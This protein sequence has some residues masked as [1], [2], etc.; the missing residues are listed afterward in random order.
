MGKDSVEISASATVLVEAHKHVHD[1]LTASTAED[2]GEPDRIA[3]H[4]AQHVINCSNMELEATQAAGIV[5]GIASSGGSDSIEYIGA[6]DLNKVA[7]AAANMELDVDLSH[8]PEEEEEGADGDG[9]EDDVASCISADNSDT[10]EDDSDAE[11]VIGHHAGCQTGC[12]ADGH[13]TSCSANCHAGCSANCHVGCC[14]DAEHP[15]SAL[16]GQRAR[17]CGPCNASPSDDEKQEDAD[18]EG[19]G[20]LEREPEI[21]LLQHFHMD[22]GNC[23]GS[24]KTYHDAEGNPVVVAAAHHYAYRDSRLACFN[25]HEFHRIFQLRKMDST[26]YPRDRIWHRVQTQYLPRLLGAAHL[27]SLIRRSLAA[28]LIQ[29]IFRDRYKQW[30][31]GE[32]DAYTFATRI[33]LRM[34]LLH[35]RNLLRARIGGGPINERPAALPLTPQNAKGRHVLVARER[36]PDYDCTEHDGTGWEAKVIKATPRWAFVDFVH[37]RD[38]HG[39]RYKREWIKLNELQP[40]VVEHTPS[41]VGRPCER[42]L[43]HAPHPLHDSHII[44]RRAKW[45]VTAPAGKPPPSEPDPDK[46]DTRARRRAAGEFARYYSALFIPWTAWSPPGRTYEHWIMHVNQLEKDACLYDPREQ[47]GDELARR[48][49]LIAAARLFDIESLKE[50][51]NA[52]KKSSVLNMKLRSMYRTFWNDSNRPPL[53]ESDVNGEQRSAAKEIQKLR[54]KAERMRGKKDIATRLNEANTAK[55]AADLLRAQLP[56]QREG[57]ASVPGSKLCEL[58]RSAA[59]PARRTTRGVSRDVRDVSKANAQPIPARNVTSLRE[60]PNQLPSGIPPPWLVTNPTVL[61]TDSPFAEITSNDYDRAVADWKAS[62]DAGLPVDKPPLNPEQRDGGRDFLRVARLRAGA[63]QRGEPIE[64]IAQAVA[65]EELSLVTLAMGAG[66]TGK[67]EMVHELDAQMQ[68]MGC[69]HLLVTAYTGVAAA[70][71]KGPTL[72]S[73][74]NLGVESKNAKRVEQMSHGRRETARKKFFN[75]CGV[76]IENIGGIVI[77]EVSFNELE[78]FG[79]L[80]GRLRQLTGNMDVLCGG[81]P[82]LLCG[83]NFQKPPTTGNPWYKDMAK[84]AEEQGAL[85]AGGPTTSKARG[86]ELLQA[87]RRVQLWRNMR[88]RFDQPFVEVQEQMRNTD[89][90][91]PVPAAFVR[92]LRKV[93]NRDLE[94]DEEWRFAPVGVLQREERDV[95]NVAQAEAF[96]RTFGVPLIRWRLE[97]VDEIDDACLRIDVY[98]DED[99]LWGYF[100]EGAPI[101]LTENISSTR[102]LVNGS[103]GILDSLSFA[104]RVIPPELQAAYANA[105]SLRGVDVVRV[106][107]A[108]APFSVNVRVGGVKSPPGQEPGSAPGSV[109]W[110]GVELDDLSSVIESVTPEA[111]VVS[112]LMSTNV[113]K[114]AVVLRGLVAAQNSLAEKVM[115]AKQHAY[116]LAFALTD[117]K[118][119]GR[120]LPKLI[121]NIFKRSTPPWMNLASFYVLISRCRTSDSLRLLQY[122]R[123][124]LEA[125]CA[126]KHDDYLVAWE[127]AYDNGRWSDALAVAA[128]ER[129]RR[130]RQQAKAARAAEKK[131]KDAQRT[132]A[133]RKEAAER[134]RAEKKAKAAA[135]AASP[136]PQTPPPILRTRSAS[137]CAPATLSRGQPAHGV[138]VEHAM[139]T[140]RVLL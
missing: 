93:S 81:I 12:S 130:T 27:L 5:L 111:Q 128:L 103:A 40:L 74:F 45:G 135:A 83:D 136:L 17:F 21:D 88:A 41:R 33:Q 120:T 1:E 126:L 73:V 124:G 59:T 122:D 7:S 96:A 62:K 110:H 133:K 54:E 23:E 63:L 43:L 107:L 82:L 118:L 89:A 99:H 14:A 53:S 57:N 121:I 92:A 80:D 22:G 52:P 97:M 55:A 25:G 3:K 61:P 20:E 84:N 109:L 44:V 138:Q 91:R 132:A 15:K 105:A 37:A 94:D 36:W 140:R 24:S 70:P 127:H 134:R 71:F 85:L 79:H 139:L 10:E 75:E 16:F 98:A 31:A 113:K 28:T 60:K 46:P 6:W 86:L 104:G 50:G 8:V 58:W 90:E 116:R 47:V 32:K 115:I 66:G 49:R 101:N 29:S 106:D 131:E 48:Q 67:S 4:F 68:A 77:D 34:R 64:S 95:I 42:Y 19:D 119:Q 39:V 117:F 13:H 18:A 2:A 125:V 102:G 11:H 56:S 65:A 137:E 26:Q 72:L 78:I 123:E 129:V 114:D 76:K 51:F 30:A 69:G 112:L 100:V 35:V 108:E 9:A 38:E 87:A